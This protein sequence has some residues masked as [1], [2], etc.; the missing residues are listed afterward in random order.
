MEEKPTPPTH[1][2]ALCNIK[3]KLERAI[4]CLKDESGELEK[5]A[6]EPHK[7]S[8]KWN[9]LKSDKRREIHEE[10]IKH[11]EN[12]VEHHQTYRGLSS[13]ARDL[14]EIYKKSQDDDYSEICEQF[15][16]IY[17]EAKKAIGIFNDVFYP[18]ML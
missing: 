5:L 15:E 2:D 1:K 14:L 16:K 17:E 8:E 11:K 12:F 10:F 4:V 9:N 7:K 3:L 18:K 6:S 13:R